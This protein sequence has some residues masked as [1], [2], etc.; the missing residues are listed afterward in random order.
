MRNSILIENKMFGFFASK[1]QRTNDI[2]RNYRPSWRGGSGAFLNQGKLFA[3]IT[4]DK[5]VRMLIW[6]TKNNAKNVVAEKFMVF[7]VK[8]IFVELVGL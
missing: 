2:C 4:R 8:L 5:K 6:V 7:Y 3:R 1:I